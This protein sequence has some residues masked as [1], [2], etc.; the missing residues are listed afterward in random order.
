MSENH[1]FDLFVF[2]NFTYFPFNKKHREKALAERQQT[3]ADL[4]AKIAAMESK[5]L[6]GGK[7]VVTHTREQEQELNRHKLIQAEQERKER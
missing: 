2:T 1:V 6:R 3:N 5:L 4:A 7:D